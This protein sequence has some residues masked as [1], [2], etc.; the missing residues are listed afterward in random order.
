M[1]FAVEND[2]LKFTEV[3]RL[4]LERQ[5]VLTDLGFNILELSQGEKKNC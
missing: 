2:A 1:S 3:N 5:S 4:L